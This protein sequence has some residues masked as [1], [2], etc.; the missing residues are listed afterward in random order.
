M[1]LWPGHSEDQKAPLAH[2]I[3]ERFLGVPYSIENS[4]SVAIEAIRPGDWMDKVCR[5][6]IAPSMTR[7]YKKPGYDPL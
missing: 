4:L 3:V 1:K 6:G 2:A 7:L 5:Q